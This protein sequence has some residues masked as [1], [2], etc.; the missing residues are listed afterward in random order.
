MRLPPQKGLESSSQIKFFF[1]GWQAAHSIGIVGVSVPLILLPHAVRELAR[2]SK[3]TARPCPFN[4]SVPVRLP[5]QKGLESSS[6]SR[7]QALGIAVRI[8]VRLPSTETSRKFSSRKQAA[9]RRHRRRLNARP[10]TERSR[11]FFSN[12]VFLLGVAG[13]TQNRHSRHPCPFNTSVP[14]RLPQQKGLE[15]SSGSRQQAL[16]TAGS[17]SQKKVF[18]LRGSRQAASTMLVPPQKG[19]E[20][21]S[22]IKFFFIVGVPVP[23]ILLPHARELARPSKHT[24]RSCPFNTS[25]PVRLPPQKGLESSSGSRQQ[26]LGIAVRIP[27]RLPSTETSR[28]FSSRKQAARRRHHRRLNARKFFSNKVFLLGVAGSTQNRHSRHPC[29]FNTSV[30]VR[31]P[32][33]KGLESSS[34]SRQQ[35][36]GIAVRIPVRL[37]STETSREFISKK[38]FSSSR[39]QAARRRHRRRPNARPST[40]RSR[41]FFSNKVFL[42]V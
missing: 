22:Q 12:K 20:S 41:K 28:K 14:V 5:P 29:P 25:V 40:E 33:Q 11:K 2:P 30:P 1:L 3:H 27:V 13:S 38:S 31:L 35:A 18:H 6:G 16:G 32:P 23:L 37:P 19:L 36:L 15:S 4:T 39:K 10:S 17:S 42:L 24:A 9:R 26:A 21:S 34:G 8:P 7:Q